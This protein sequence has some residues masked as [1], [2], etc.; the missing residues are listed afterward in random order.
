MPAYVLPKTLL[1]RGWSSV[2]EYELH[3]ERE[4]QKIQSRGRGWDYFHRE[5][6]PVLHNPEQRDD[7]LLK[8]K[9]RPIDGPGVPG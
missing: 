2:E 7:L 3:R 8:W 1:K 6:P 5:C 4:F 9:H